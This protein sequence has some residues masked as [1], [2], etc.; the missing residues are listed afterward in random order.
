MGVAWEVSTPRHSEVTDLISSHQRYLRL[1]FYKKF[2][3]CIPRQ[4]QTSHR[5]DTANYMC[6]RMVILKCKNEHA[7]SRFPLYDVCMIP[8]TGSS[9]Q[10]QKHSERLHDAQLT[11]APLRH[12]LIL[13]S[14]PSRMS[15]MFIFVACF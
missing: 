13:L 14:H 15:W 1:I 10:R 9:N 12:F 7:C 4:G 11:Y 8:I 2:E 3:K 5:C 6:T